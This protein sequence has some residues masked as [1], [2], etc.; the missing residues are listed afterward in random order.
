[1]RR[2][3]KSGRFI[4]PDQMPDPTAHIRQTHHKFESGV[5]HNK[6]L[7][8]DLGIYARLRHLLRGFDIIQ[9][10]ELFDR[11]ARRESDRMQSRLIIPFFQIIT[12]R[13]R[14]RSIG[15]IDRRRR[16]THECV[17]GRTIDYAFNI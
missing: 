9:S 11:S 6:R 12:T 15:N 2:I 3:S 13:T 14:M 17:I 7:E 10:E 16:R 4:G 1:M 5:Q 8:C